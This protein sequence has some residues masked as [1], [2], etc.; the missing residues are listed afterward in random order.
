M[1]PFMLARKELVSCLKAGLDPEICERFDDKRAVSE[2]C[3]QAG[4]PSPRILAWTEGRERYHCE[5]DVDLPALE[6][7]LFVKPLNGIRGGGAV[8]IT[9]EGGEGFRWGADPELREWADLGKALL[10]HARDCEDDVIVQMCVESHP[11][12]AKLTGDRLST[13]RVVTC[14][15]EG[16][17]SVVL[18]TLCCPGAGRSVDNF[19]QGGM[20]APICV[21]SGRISGPACQKRGRVGIEWH[22]NHPD[23]GERFEGFAIPRWN[24]VL[25]LVLRAHEHFRAL[26]PSA[27]WDVAIQEE[28]PYLMEINPVWGADVV[29]LSNQRGLLDSPFATHVREEWAMTSAS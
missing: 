14:R 13:V 7:G 18:A 28:G 9:N 19:A 24:E 15:I 17:P 6:A 12:V 4:I 3:R 1:L 21:E 20:A 26:I 29:Q 22:E 16:R 23:Q 27:G 25:E 11:T 5:S 8:R 10:S 2:A